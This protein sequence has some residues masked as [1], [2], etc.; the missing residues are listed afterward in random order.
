MIQDT[1]FIQYFQ[2]SP[3]NYIRK[4]VLIRK[5]KLCGLSF[6]Q[7][8]SDLYKVS[9][10]V[11]KKVTRVLFLE[12]EALGS[13]SEFSLWFQKA[14]LLPQPLYTQTINS[15]IPANNIWNNSQGFWEWEVVKNITKV[16][17]LQVKIMPVL[18]DCVSQMKVTLSR[19]QYG[20]FP[21][22][23]GGEEQY[24]KN[25]PGQPFL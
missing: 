11:H 3:R 18:Q 17:T 10:K 15:S 16:S 20:K 7:C 1:W 12:K 14:L 23:G 6:L 9:C 22:A 4:W 2:S 25:L 13:G 8:G 24:R 21:F 19:R 5:Q